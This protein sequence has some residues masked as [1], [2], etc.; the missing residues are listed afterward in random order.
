[1]D[2]NNLIFES[3][4][5]TLKPRKMKN[6]ETL[7]IEAKNIMSKEL[8]SVKRDITYNSFTGKQLRKVFMSNCLNEIDEPFISSIASYKKIESVYKNG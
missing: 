7:I 6:T 1:M 2:F 8:R 3:R 4:D 5:C